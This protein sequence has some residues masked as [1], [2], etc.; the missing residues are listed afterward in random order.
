[1]SERLAVTDPTNVSW[2]KDVSVDREVV[3]RLREK[4]KTG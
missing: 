1:M 2:Q 4:L 3:E